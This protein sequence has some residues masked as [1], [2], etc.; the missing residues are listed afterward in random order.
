[1]RKTTWVKLGIAAG[2]LA[3]LAC[4]AYLAYR[5]TDIFERTGISDKI[6]KFSGNKEGLFLNN[7]TQG[8]YVSKKTG[9]PLFLSDDLV[10][11]DDG[12]LSFSKP[13]TPNSVEYI[14]DR[15]E[16]GEE[17]VGITTPTDKEVIGHVTEENSGKPVFICKR[18]A[19][20]FIPVADSSDFAD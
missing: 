11:D 1:M 10:K 2:L 7:D 14:V 19:L 6:K 18:T 3:G 5:Y 17:R 4:G 13:M 20:K 12:I 8:I 16:I 15:S 9:E